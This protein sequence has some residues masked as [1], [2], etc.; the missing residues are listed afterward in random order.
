MN[1][2]IGDFIITEKSNIPGIIIK[3][4]N[5]EKN[6]DNYKYLVFIYNKHGGYIIEA[7]A[8]QIKKTSLEPHEELSIIANLG[9]RFYNQYTELYQEILIRYII[10][11]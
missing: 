11:K 8:N 6:K 1:L 9:G 7:N 5:K 3:E 2:T 4:I 10:Y